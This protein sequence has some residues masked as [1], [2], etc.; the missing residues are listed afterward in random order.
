MCSI[1][2]KLSRTLLHHVDSFAYQ[3]LSSLCVTKIVSFLCTLVNR[4][5]FTPDAEHYCWIEKRTS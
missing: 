5:L 3:K 1:S 2:L 4:G